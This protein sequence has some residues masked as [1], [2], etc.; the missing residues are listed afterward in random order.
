L[1]FACLAG[2]IYLAYTI[3]NATNHND[4]G[5]C[6]IKEASGYPGPSCGS[7]RSVMSII[8]GNFTEALYWNPIGV[9]LVIILAVTPFWLIFDLVLG[10]DSVLKFYFNIEH[11]FNQKKYAI[12]AIVLVL[13]NWIWNFYKGL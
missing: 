10:K 5:V 3:S 4:F 11:V 7:T 8:H 9:I 12:P 13:A 6:I 2:Y 1:A